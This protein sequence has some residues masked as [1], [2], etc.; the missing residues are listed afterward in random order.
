M[1]ADIA[2]FDAEKIIDKATY[3]DPHNF[4]EGIHHVIVNGE[5]AVR[6]GRQTDAKPGKVLR[7]GIDVE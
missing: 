6:D 1:F 5:F 7:K 2:V 4:P 3:H